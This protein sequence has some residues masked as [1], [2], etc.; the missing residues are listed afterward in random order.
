MEVSYGVSVSIPSEAQH[1][2]ITTY[3]WPGFLGEFIH[4][5][6]EFDVWELVGP[7]YWIPRP[8]IVAPPRECIGI[9]TTKGWRWTSPQEERWLTYPDSALWRRLQL[10]SPY[11]R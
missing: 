4:S 6:L 11:S 7:T 8:D 5:T 9:E 1:T 2:E 3:M 10:R